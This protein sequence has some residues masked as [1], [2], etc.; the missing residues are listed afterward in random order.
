[1]SKIEAGKLT[2]EDLDFN[3]VKTVEGTLDMLAQ[4][5]QDKGLE[6]AGT[7]ASEV[8]TRLRGDPGRLR[9]ILVNLVGNAIKFTEQGEVVVRVCKETETGNPCAGAILRARH[10][11]RHFAGS[12]GEAVSRL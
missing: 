11:Y 5:A 7:V 10:R 3:L 8:P 1:L 9:Q 2:F 6:L 4:R 12:A